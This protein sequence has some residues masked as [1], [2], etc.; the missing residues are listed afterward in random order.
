[1]RHAIAVCVMIVVLV[2]LAGD[3]RAQVVVYSQPNQNP[4]GPYSDGVPGQY[5]STRIAD[6]FVFSDPTNRRITQVTWWGSSENMTSPD[7]SHFSDWVIRF[8]AD[9][10]NLPGAELY[11]ETFPKDATNPVPTGNENMDGG[12]EYE[13][14]VELS[15]S[16]TLYIDEPY[17]ISIG[18]IN[19]PPEE[20][21]WHWSGNY[22]SGD[23]RLA[24]DY[25]DGTGYHEYPDDEDVAFELWGLPAGGCPRPGC[26]VG[27][28]DGDCDIDLTD[29][30]ILLAHYGETGVGPD[31]GDLNGDTNVDL[32]DLAM[33]LSVYGADCN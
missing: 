2:S 5:Y 33:L 12:D 9:S 4:N 7:L 3:G 11:N 20:D 17:W 23:D 14:H 21:G 15:T 18:S 27:D 10:D 31:E 32:A 26:E 30:S 13:Q 29:L 28:I 19:H 8:Y 6:N 16:L 24:A 1:M 25:F 22:T